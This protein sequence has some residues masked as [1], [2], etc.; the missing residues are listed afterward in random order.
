MD[1]PTYTQHLAAIETEYRTI[2]RVLEAVQEKM[3]RQQMHLKED[4]KN[5]VIHITAYELAFNEQLRAYRAKGMADV[6]LQ[7]DLHRSTNLTSQNY[8]TLLLD[9]DNACVANDTI[10][11]F[12]PI[13]ALLNSYQK[14]LCTI[15]TC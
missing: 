11:V 7:K 1:T 15:Q 10:L 2:I 13:A 12:S 4:I 8:K 9:S 6:I 14:T 5:E 3:T